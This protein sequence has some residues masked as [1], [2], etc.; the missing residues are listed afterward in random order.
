MATVVIDFQQHSEKESRENK[1]SGSTLVLQLW[2]K[3]K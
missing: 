1:A 2:N 3:D